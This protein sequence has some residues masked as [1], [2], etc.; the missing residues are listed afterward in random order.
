MCPPAA[1]PMAASAS[2][3]NVQSLATDFL[4]KSSPPSPMCLT[5]FKGFSWH[6]AE[7]KMHMHVFK[8]DKVPKNKH[9]A[10]LLDNHKLLLLH[11]EH[12]YLRSSLVVTLRYLQ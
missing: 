10:L 9:P 7:Y 4:F 1:F 12:V 8:V 3:R 2:A 5:T 6:E 11:K